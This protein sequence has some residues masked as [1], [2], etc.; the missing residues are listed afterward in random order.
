M[1]MVRDRNL[2]HANL[3]QRIADLTSLVRPQ[4]T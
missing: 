4:L 2:M 1:G 3:S